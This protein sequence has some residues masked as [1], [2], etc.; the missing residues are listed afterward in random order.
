[1][2]GC[3]LSYGARRVFSGLSLRVGR[4]ESVAVLG[5]SGAGKTS[6]LSLI[7]GERRPDEGEAR[8]MG[9]LPREGDPAVAAVPQGAELFPW[10]KV[11][12]NVSI[13]LDAIAPARAER[14]ARVGEALS[15]VGLQ[16]RAK[17]YPRELS[18]GE[19]QRVA[20]ARAFVRRPRLILLDEPFSSLDA[21]TREEMQAL[22][23]ELTS[24][25]GATSILVTHSIEEAAFL[26]D[27]VYVLSAGGRL[28]RAESIRG[29]ATRPDPSG[30]AAYRESKE[31][32]EAVRALR[33][34]FDAVA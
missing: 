18:G 4:G 19:R 20:L 14:R 15:Q 21:I 5:R 8:V 9:R 23:L 30:A 10:M 12:A 24:A 29:K 3:A 31:Y 1:M 17:A 13:A 34:E 22:F 33:I 32:A 27:S 2:E 16:G 28:A 6:L 11:S 7:S 26:G 25:S